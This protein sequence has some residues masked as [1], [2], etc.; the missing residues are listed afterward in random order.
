MK[1]ILFAII[2]LAA[3]VAAH[4]QFT[5]PGQ[6]VIGATIGFNSSNNQSYSLPDYDTKGRYFSGSVSAGKFKK[7]NV[8]NSVAVFYNNSSTKQTT[9][10]NT[11]ENNSNGVTLTFGKTYFKEVAKK[12]YVGLGGFIGLGYGSSIMKNTQN[13][14]RGESDGYNIGFS[15]EPNMS[16]QLT[17]RFLLTLGPSAN[18]LNL[19]YN[20]SKVSYT[21]AGQA[22]T[23]G[24]IQNIGLNTGFF[25]SPLSNITFGFRYL[26]KQK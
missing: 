24:K 7:K 21:E 22:G 9:P 18:F 1:I 20:Y 6:K 12:L 26:L 5:Q 3:G 16:Y 19:N 13:T 25:N 17:D 10:T 4:A 8:L 14:S 23:S 15:I 11:S 2:M